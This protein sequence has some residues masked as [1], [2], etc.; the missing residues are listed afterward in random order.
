MYLPMFD[1]NCVPRIF[2]HIILIAS[3]IYV[4]IYD[5][6]F[7]GLANIA[8]MSFTAFRFKLLLSIFF[9]LKYFLKTSHSYM[10]NKTFNYRILRLY[11]TRFCEVL[12]RFD[13]ATS[14]FNIND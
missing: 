9:S 5:K 8:K 3:R 11:C 13:G 2:V 4:I 7:D 10:F 14:T 1:V 6:M 12:A